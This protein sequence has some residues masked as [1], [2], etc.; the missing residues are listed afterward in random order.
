MFDKG[1]STG[2]HDLTTQRVPAPSPP[3][4]WSWFSSLDMNVG[5][6]DA[7]AMSNSATAVRNNREDIQAACNQPS[8][9][10]CP[11]R[12]ATPMN[13]ANLYFTMGLPE[14]LEAVML[15]C[16]GVAWPCASL[17][18]LRT[19]RL[20]SNG[21]GFTLVIL[22]GYLFGASSKMLV[23]A[24]G[25]E[26]APVFW[27]YAVNAVSVA[28][29]LGLQ[30]RY[31]S[32]RGG[33]HVNGRASKFLGMHGTSPAL[34]RGPTLQSDPL[35]GDR[36]GARGCECAAP[37]SHTQRPCGI[38]DGHHAIALATTGAAHRVER[39]MTWLE[40]DAPHR[41]RARRLTPGSRMHPNDHTSIVRTPRSA[42]DKRLRPLRSS[43]SRPH[44]ID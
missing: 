41:F 3:A 21:L 28:A 33:F 16:F 40:V 29:N 37:R 38:V 19:G 9:V 20:Q 36:T 23:A 39:G 18:M 31:G 42:L 27:L 43:G 32:R 12:S 10:A 1:S 5:S 4:R 14:V 7:G 17:K 34:E 30:L 25:A 11:G 2:E 22:C 6:K 24:R 44:W 8:L 35:R 13:L 15:V 26:L